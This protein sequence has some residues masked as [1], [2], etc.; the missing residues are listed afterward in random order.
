M[1]EKT[2]MLKADNQDF[3]LQPIYTAGRREGEPLFEYRLDLVMPDGTTCMR[4]GGGSR[5]TDSGCS[6]G[7]RSFEQSLGTLPAR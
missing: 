3:T 1:R 4:A 2:I 7:S 5:A 6:S